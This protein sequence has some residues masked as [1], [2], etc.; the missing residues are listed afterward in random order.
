[1]KDSKLVNILPPKSLTSQNRHVSRSANNSL[2]AAF[3]ASSN[4][5]PRSNVVRFPRPSSSPPAFRSS[6]LST[7]HFHDPSLDCQH[8]S[9]LSSLGFLLARQLSG[10]CI[11][12]LPVFFLPPFVQIS[13][14]LSDITLRLNRMWG[15]CLLSLH[16]VSLSLSISH[17]VSLSLVVYLSPSLYLSLSVSVS[18]KSYIIR[19]A[20]I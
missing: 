16:S 17:Y 15:R 1:M 3:V 12:W 9:F 4:N 11:T 20:V 18:H 10:R 14:Y 2:C 13:V 7:A 5:L 6:L 8:V 19:L